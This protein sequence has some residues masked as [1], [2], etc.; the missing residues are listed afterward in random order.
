MY[1]EHDVLAEIF[2][3]AKEDLKGA[4]A[5]LPDLPKP[6]SLKIEDVKRADYAFA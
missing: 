4:K 6:G 5:T 3:R 2:E 1:E